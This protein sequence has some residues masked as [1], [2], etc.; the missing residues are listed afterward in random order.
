M[1]RSTTIKSLTMCKYNKTGKY[2][3]DKPLSGLSLAQA[4]VKLAELKKGYQ[5]A[6]LQKVR[7]SKDTHQ[8]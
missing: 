7:H 5:K 3:D 6:A 8:E 4:R 1:Q 2:K